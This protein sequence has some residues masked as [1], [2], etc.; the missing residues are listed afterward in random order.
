M[1]LK[2]GSFILLL[3]FSSTVFAQSTCETRVDSHQKASTPQRVEYCLTQDV[4]S[5]PT[6]ARPELIYSEVSSYQPAV[7]EKQKEYTSSNPYF[8]EDKYTITQ[9]YVGTTQFPAFQNAIMSEQE[10]AA[11]R[12]AWLEQQG[13]LNPSVT[14][15][16]A[17][18]TAT[19]TTT[20]TT[21]TTANTKPA[22]TKP[23]VTKP[24]V[25][26]TKA[27]ITRRSTKPGRTMK[28][29]AKVEKT[30]SQETSS[31]QQ[32]PTVTTT[33]TTTATTETTASTATQP[34]EE[35]L[36]LLPNN[37]Y[38]QPEDLTTNETIPYGDK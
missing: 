4:Y 3:V 35:E 9:G 37:P 7:Q 33:T 6:E 17:R 29:V 11:N 5:A 31:A 15:V 34:S 30:T 8:K 27:G 21:T 12:Q 24:A 26:E 23:A 20:T 25:V 36:G 13:A 2:I 1:H 22:V 38:A 14:P 10:I 28:Q 16:A 19:T 32:T 18:P